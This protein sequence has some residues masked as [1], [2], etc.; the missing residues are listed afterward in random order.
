MALC[1][2]SPSPTR[3]PLT[4]GALGIGGIPRERF[5]Q[6][7]LKNMTYLWLCLAFLALVLVVCRWLTRSWAGL[8]C[9]A[10]REDETAASSM[11][12]SPVRFKLFAFVL[13]RAGSTEGT[14][15]QKPWRHQELQWSDRCHS[16]L[17]PGRRSRQGFPGSDCQRRR[18]SL[19]WY[20]QR[21][22]R[23]HALRCEGLSIRERLFRGP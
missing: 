23:H 19:L 7:P 16:R 9:F 20:G 8:A 3:M 4:V 15:V 12:I 17:Y 5:F 14:E 22:C 10:L 11:G 13:R 2:F 21:P 6:V 1:A 18:L